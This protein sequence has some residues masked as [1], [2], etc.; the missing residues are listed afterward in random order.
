VSVAG[1]ATPGQ[2]DARW[3][4]EHLRLTDVSDD[5]WQVLEVAGLTHLLDASR[6]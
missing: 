3:W 4:W 2:L 5:C 1:R 6:V